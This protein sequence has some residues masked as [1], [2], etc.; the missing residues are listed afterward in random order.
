MTDPFIHFNIRYSPP[1][2][3]LTPSSEYSRSPRE[4]ADSETLLSLGYG[5]SLTMQ[6]RSIPSVFVD[7]MIGHHH[8]VGQSTDMMISGRGMM[9]GYGSGSGASGGGL[10]SLSNCYNSRRGSA[11]RI[12][13]QIPV[14]AV[15]GAVEPSRSMLD[16]PHSRKSSAH[17]L[18]IPMEQP[19]RAS[20][21]DGDNI[22]IVIDEVK[23]CAV[24]CGGSHPELLITTA[25]EVEVGSDHQRTSVM[26]N[27]GTV[28]TASHMLS[29]TNNSIAQQQKQQQQ[30]QQKHEPGKTRFQERMRAVLNRA[31][32]IVTHYERVIL[33]RDPFDYSI[34]TR[35]FGI[36]VIGGRLCEDGN[37]YAHVSWINSGGSA[38]KQGVKLG[39][40]I[41]EWNSR[42][43][44]NCSYEQ[45]C[46]IIDSCGDQ[47]ELIVESMVKW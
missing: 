33:K 43:L 11:G 40:Q 10:L 35:G 47:A 27:D 32:S 8:S 17:S 14:L 26:I 18:D 24:T 29:N 37:L 41:L 30:Q 28:S 9:M 31:T 25:T 20:A 34:R 39:D 6:R 1:Q 4:S 46:H 22:R 16:L 3:S 23:D 13:P 5:S 7:S 21:P 19:R 38:D 45:V 44:V 42:S 12:L 15:G 2:D 36:C